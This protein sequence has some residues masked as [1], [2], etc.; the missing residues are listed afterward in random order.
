MTAELDIDFTSGRAESG[1]PFR[2]SGD[3]L[4]SALVICRAEPEYPLVYV[5]RAFL[6]Y[7]GYG[8]AEFFEKTGGR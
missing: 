3:G 7:V 1:T 6:A 5:N 2:I 8:H 4:S